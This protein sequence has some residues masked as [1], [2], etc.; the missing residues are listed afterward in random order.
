MLSTGRV[1]IQSQLKRIYQEH[2]HGCREEVPVAYN[3][4]V[5]MAAGQRYAIY[6]QAAVTG[7]IRTVCPTHPMQHGRL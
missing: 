1:Q 4:A 7:H 5:S 3:E 6:G 2:R